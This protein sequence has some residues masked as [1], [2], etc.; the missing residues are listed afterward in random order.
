MQLIIP[1]GIPPYDGVKGR[2]FLIGVPA[3]PLSVFRYVKGYGFLKLQ[4]MKV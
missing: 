1:V 3:E 2:L 4:Y